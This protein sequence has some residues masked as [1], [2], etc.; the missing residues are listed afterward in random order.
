MATTP[1]RGLASKWHEFKVGMMR[2]VNGAFSPDWALQLVPGLGQV[3]LTPGQ[4]V[5]RWDKVRP[6]KGQ[7]IQPGSFPDVLS[8]GTHISPS[9]LAPL[10]LTLSP[11]LFLGP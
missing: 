2:T 4:V 8:Q 9:S 3:T 7:H 6:F 10:R 5:V 11:L 1:E